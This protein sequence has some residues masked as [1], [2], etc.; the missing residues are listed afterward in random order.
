MRWP[1]KDQLPD[2]V[3][4]PFGVLAFLRQNLRSEQSSWT[5]ASNSLHCY[6]VSRNGPVLPFAGENRVMVK[7]DTAAARQQG[8]LLWYSVPARVPSHRSKARRAGHEA[9]RICRS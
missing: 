1:G 3:S 4:F 6:V 8:C 7:A 5:E 9:R 2:T